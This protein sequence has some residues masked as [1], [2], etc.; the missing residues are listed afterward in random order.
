MNAQRIVRLVVFSCFQLLPAI[1]LAQA[2]SGNIVGV[3]KDPSGA[4]LPGVSVEAASPALIERSRTAV[5]DEQ[6]R[7]RIG[8]LRPGT[9]TVTFTL[10]G[11]STLKRDSIELTTGFTATV[12]A[13][14]KVG[15]LEETI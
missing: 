2:D 1:L 5:S 12:N 14:L 3:V 9:Y 6:G 13:D 15:T 11:F 8:D 7:Y 10:P 4:V